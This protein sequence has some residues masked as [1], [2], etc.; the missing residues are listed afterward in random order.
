MRDNPWLYRLRFA[1][2]FGAAILLSLCIIDGFF[3]TDWAG[4]LAL[5]P[6]A[7]LSLTL[8]LCLIAPYFRRWLK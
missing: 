3:G 7:G 8:V 6:I 1:A 4:V 2:V 5:S